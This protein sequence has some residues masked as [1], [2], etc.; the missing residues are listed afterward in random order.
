MNG[1]TMMMTLA[2]LAFAMGATAQPQQQ[3]GLTEKPES[4]KNNSCFNLYVFKDEE[5]GKKLEDYWSQQV[6][7]L[8]SN[9]RGLLTDAF[10]TMM[11]GPT[12]IMGLITTGIDAATKMVKGKKEEWLQRIQGENRFEKELKTLQNIDDFYSGPSTASALDPS[13][14]IFNGFGCK[15]TRGDETVLSLSCHLDTARQAFSRIFRHSKFQLRVDTLIFNPF[16]CDLPNDT[17]ILYSD[18]FPFSFEERSNLRLNI[19][20]DIISS[21]INQAIQVHKDEHLGMFTLNVDINE[22]DLKNGIFRFIRGAEDNSVSDVQLLGECFIVPRSYIGVRD[23]QGNYYDAWGTGEYKVVM[24]IEETCD[25]APQLLEGNNW[26]TDW[27]KRMDREGWVQ[28]PLGIVQSVEQ[29]FDE[30]ANQWVV[31][32]KEVPAMALEN[33]NGIGKSIMKWQKGRGVKE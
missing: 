24:N 12:G 8:E 25:I 14:M 9:N 28:K 3:Q 29:I 22:R 5:L 16:L 31:M 33:L 20:F 18:R 15:Q 4:N 13:S 27:K 10:Q 17:S 21:W 30:R 1:K 19:R 32:V 2:A 11:A 26:K 6:E 23:E 7:A